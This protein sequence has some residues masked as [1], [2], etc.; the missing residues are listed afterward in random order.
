MVP[1]VSGDAGAAQRLS[2]D[3]DLLADAVYVTKQRVAAIVGAL[4]A[5]WSGPAAQSIEVPVEEF[6]RNAATLVRVLDE[7]ASAY[8]EYSR[9]LE[10]AH[11][12]HRW[13][14]HK[15]L[16]VGAVAAVSATAVVVTVGAA[17]VV[18]AAAAGAAVGGASEAAEAG[19]LADTMAAAAVDSALGALPSLR[20]LLSFVLPH[21]LQAEWVAGA[22]ATWDEATTNHLRWRALAETAALAFAAAG[23]AAGG[24]NLVSGSRW[25]PHVVEGAAWGGSAAAGD[26]LIDHRLS[27]ADI[28]ET[29]VLAGGSTAGR[30]ALRAHG[31]WPESPDY[32]REAL[33][34][35]LH[36]PGLVMDRDIAHELAVLRQPVRD[37][38]RG[39]VD[40][41]L[42]EGPGHTID[43][44]V[45]KT[46]AE[47]RARLQTDRIPRASTYW[48]PNGARDAIEAT[49]TANRDAI[50]RWSAAGYP[51]TLRLRMSSP[52][53]LGMVVNRRGLVRFVRHAVV[54]LRHDGA[55]VVMV[56][57]FPA[58]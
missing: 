31:M 56:T 14:M 2:V 46:T 40:L 33:V 28:G 51:A 16:K 5:A 12:A 52:Y 8:A 4:S 10:A 44:H 21:L 41:R 35:L 9:R 24:R 15:I 6:L 45:S 37:L 36:R 1:K 23:T 19:L 7:V 42:H 22:T 11:A 57:S 49:L 30:D 13:S 29:F 48:D 17:G 54:V 53:D 32:R 47:L 39:A 58:P 3:Y 43:R 27:V 26:E 34:N 50:R 18:E 25:A 38:E 55:G 20:P